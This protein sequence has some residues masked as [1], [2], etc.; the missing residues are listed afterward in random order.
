MRRPQ[1]RRSPAPWRRVHALPAAGATIV[2]ADALVEVAQHGQVAL[3][4]LRGQRGVQR[5]FGAVGRHDHR[6]QLP[7][8]V[9][10][11]ATGVTRA[12]TGATGSPPCDGRAQIPVLARAA[13]I[14]RVEAVLVGTRVHVAADGRGRLQR[15]CALGDRRA[16]VARVKA[17]CVVCAVVVA[18]LRAL[19]TSMPSPVVSA[20]RPPRLVICTVVR[21]L[22]MAVA[23]SSTSRSL[24][25]LLSPSAVPR[26][27]TPLLP[28]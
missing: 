3:A 9:G 13:G 24:A 10:M 1:A 11:P 14:G 28:T 20:P 8:V 22:A 7:V 2:V 12:A 18:P 21:P 16:A 15:G 5:R 25:L 4:Q 23:P 17:F 26:R 27:S 19:M 6:A